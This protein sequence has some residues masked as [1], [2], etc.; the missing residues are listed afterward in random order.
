[1]NEIE[2]FIAETA[3]EVRGMSVS[4]ARTYLR[5]LLMLIGENSAIDSL[6]EIYRHLD[7]AD[8]QIELIADPQA[9]LNLEGGSQDG[10]NKA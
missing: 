9:K 7:V 4:E 3:A 6:R 5:G 1:M 10:G 2:F 8:A